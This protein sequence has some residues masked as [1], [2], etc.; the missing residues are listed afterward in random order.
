MTGP[1]FTVRTLHLD[2]PGLAA[3]FGR[4]LHE[5]GV[6]TT[7][8]RAVR[9][10]RAVE[11]GRPVSRGRLY[12]IARS[13]FLTD[14][15]QLRAFDSVFAE[16]FGAGERPAA[17]QPDESESA[18]PAPERAAG[19][20]RDEPGIAGSG[21]RT[22]GPPSDGDDDE[23]RDFLVPVAASDEEVLRSK[24]FDALSPGELA[25]LYRLM[26][27]LEMATPPRR[28]RRFARD[29]RGERIDMRR[30]LR[31]SAHTAGD[32]IRLAR[33]RRRV[34]ARRVVMLCDISGSMEPYARAYLQ[35]L[36][37]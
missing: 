12:W 2:L 6:D 31:G 28:T 24:H 36:T 17:A 30:T 32:P 26:E 20:S 8:D 34:V 29:R 9:F 1:A 5:A 3:A 11:L 21:D 15:A 37:C 19:R 25:T 33:R 13:V 14:R 10:A 23:L 27:R 16:V 22:A 7:A 35:F 4:R 18:L